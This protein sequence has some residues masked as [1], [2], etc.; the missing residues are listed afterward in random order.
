MGLSSRSFCR[1]MTLVPP[2]WRPRRGGCDK[3]RITR[4]Q[5]IFF[6]I[7][8]SQNL[9]KVYPV[10]GEY[11]EEKIISGTEIFPS[12]IIHFTSVVTSWGKYFFDAAPIRHIF[13]FWHIREFLKFQYF[14]YENREYL[15]LLGASSK[16]H[17]CTIVTL[18]KSYLLAKK[19]FHEEG[20]KD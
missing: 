17:F 2:K 10:N 20:L 9:L 5:L 15:C 12:Y 8:P 4:V 18:L 14:W 1:M 19:I 6:H 3:K 13:R 7:V 11:I 16:F